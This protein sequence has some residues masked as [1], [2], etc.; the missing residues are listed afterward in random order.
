M[1]LPDEAAKALK[2][3]QGE[4]KD[5]SLGPLP[6]SSLPEVKRAKTKSEEQTTLQKW[7]ASKACVEWRMQ[8]KKLFAQQVDSSDG[9]SESED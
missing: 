4:G 7:M 2:R 1:T 6:K 5:G 3:A 9:E 8:R